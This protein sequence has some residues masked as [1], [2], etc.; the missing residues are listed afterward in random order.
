MIY[1]LSPGPLGCF[2]ILTTVN[3]AVINF[4]KLLQNKNREA[5]PKRCFSG[6]LP[7]RVLF[8]QKGSELNSIKIY[9]KIAGTIFS[10]LFIIS[11]FKSPTARQL[12]HI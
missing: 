8:M 10:S 11:N 5:S 7:K 9:A 1:F 6:P 2:Q 3:N 12:K 4:A